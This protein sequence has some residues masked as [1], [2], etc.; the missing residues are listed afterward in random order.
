MQTKREESHL[1]CH[2]D[3]FLE[4]S[5]NRMQILQQNFGVGWNFYVKLHRNDRIPNYHIL[6]LAA[7]LTSDLLSRF[8]SVV[9]PY[10]HVIS[11]A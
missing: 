5:M 4:L 9:H 10:M 6:Q 11:R 7:D 8:G 3:S 2:F 1:L